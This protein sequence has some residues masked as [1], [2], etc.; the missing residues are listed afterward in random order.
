MNDKN[1]VK[2]IP[3]SDF[4]YMLKSRGISSKMADNIELAVFKYLY[5]Q[6]YARNRDRLLGG[7]KADAATRWLEK[8][9]DWAAYEDIINY[10]V[11]RRQGKDGTDRIHLQMLIDYKR[12][13]VL[14]DS[15]G[16][17]FHFPDAEKAMAET[18]LNRTE[19]TF[20][21]TQGRTVKGWTGMQE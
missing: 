7:M 14:F 9:K 13:F 6:V 10:L 15:K 3:V 16:M 12:P 1:S 11:A 5:P 8:E 17:E 18:G 21:V 2:K 4:L 20:M 19:F